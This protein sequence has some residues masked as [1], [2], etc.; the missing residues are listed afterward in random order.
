MFVYSYSKATRYKRYLD[1]FWNHIFSLPWSSHKQSSFCVQP[2]MYLILF[3]TLFFVLLLLLF[4]FT[5]YLERNSIYLFIYFHFYFHT[6]VGAK[7]WENIEG[8]YSRSIISL[9]RIV[10]CV[11]VCVWNEILKQEKPFQFVGK[12]LLPWC[13][14]IEWKNIYFPVN[15]SDGLCLLRY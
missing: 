13:Q 8:K 5:L 10:C 15:Q 6:F 1:M 9:Y 2:K 12:C 14:H 4:L 3:L 11:Y 7:E